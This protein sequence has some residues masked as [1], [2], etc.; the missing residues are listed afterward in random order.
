METDTLVQPR[1]FMGLSEELWEAAKPTA[2][3]KPTTAGVRVV[4]PELIR[5]EE[6][7]LRWMDYLPQD[8]IETMI[9]MGWDV[10]T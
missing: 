4:D 10:T 8:C 2:T 6:N 1:V 9:R 3:A 7:I 5:S